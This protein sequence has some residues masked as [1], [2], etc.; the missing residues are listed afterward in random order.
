MNSLLAV[1]ILGVGS[2]LIAFDH[3]DAIELNHFYDAKGRAIYDQVI[4]REWQRSTGRFHVRQWT[5][6]D[7]RDPISKRPLKNE[8]TGLYSVE[9]HDTDA[10]TSRKVVSR[11]FKESWTQIDPERED[12]KAFPES[13][14]YSLSKKKQPNEPVFSED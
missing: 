1:L 9:Y 7:D 11:V 4:F 13:L 6:I 8:E 5:L 14:R 3:V 10:K 2:R 12:K